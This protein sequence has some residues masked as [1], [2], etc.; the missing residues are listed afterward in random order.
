MLAVV[1]I[2]AAALLIER[3]ITIERNDAAG[4]PLQLIGQFQHVPGVGRRGRV[5]KALMVIDDGVQGLAQCLW[6]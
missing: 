2:V 1:E 5:R 3:H 4:I 6:R